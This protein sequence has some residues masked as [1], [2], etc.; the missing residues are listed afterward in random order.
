M[1]TILVIDDDRNLLESLLTLLEFEGY[2]PV[3]ASNG[4]DGIAL[5]REHLPDLIIC[6]II[7]PEVNGYDVLHALRDA[8]ETRTI[9]LIFLTSKAARHDQRQGMASGASDYLTKPFTF[10]EFLRAIRARLNRQDT[11][12]QVY[13]QQIDTLRQA[14][15]FA[16]PPDLRA[17]LGDILTGTD[18]LLR[19]ATTLTTG[20]VYRTGNALHTAAQQLHRQIE[21][22]LIFAQLE[23]LQLDPSRVIVQRDSSVDDPA[24]MIRATVQSA[25]EA[26]QRQDDLQLGKLASAAIRITADSLRKI[27]EELISYTLAA[28]PAGATVQ[29][30]AEAESDTYTLTIMAHDTTLP[31]AIADALSAPVRLGDQLRTHDA[32]VLGLIVAQHLLRAHNGH[33]RWHNTARRFRWVAQFARLESESTPTVSDAENGPPG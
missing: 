26:A 24:A 1:T 32:P 33:L 6:D 17:P 16:L 21:N 5:A 19:D 30:T 25:S 15:V 2:H 22:Y 12:Q 27:V 8:P 4:Q 11:V 3:G 23:I 29:V 9:P 28:S 18:H 13:Q 20:D 14:V 10:E 7:M 31:P